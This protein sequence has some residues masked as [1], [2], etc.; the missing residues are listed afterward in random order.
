MD[1]IKVKFTKNSPYNEYG[2]YDYGDTGEVVGYTNGCAIILKD[3]GSFAKADIKWIEEVKE[4]V[5]TIPT[6][7]AE[8]EDE[9]IRKELICL[10][11]DFDK[12]SSSFNMVS[13]ESMLAWLEKQGELSQSEV[14]KKSDQGEH[15]PC[16]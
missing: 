5:E 6:E 11:R 16:L 15:K 10:V 4:Q 12:E 2:H 7:L 1:R 8:S 3:D 9:K 13:Q 14:T